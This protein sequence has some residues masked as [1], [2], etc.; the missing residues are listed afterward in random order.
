MLRKL[1]RKFVAVVMLCVTILMLVT[2]GGVNLFTMNQM[3]QHYDQILKMLVD[4]SGEF[5]KEHTSTRTSDFS[6]FGYRV[7]ITEE[8]PFETRYFLVYSDEAQN[9]TDVDVTH[10]SSVSEDEAASYAQKVFNRFIKN[11]REKGTVSEY[12]Y[13]IE[14]TEDGYMIGFADMHQNLQN[15]AYIRMISAAICLSLFLILLVLVE[16]VSGRVL[17]PLI[18]NMEKQKQFITDAGHE[19]KTPLAVISA[20]ADVLE[21]TSGK[22]E[23]IDSI[24]NQVGQMN[25]LVK[26]LLY[27]SKMEEADEMV[28]AELD[29]S[30]LVKEVSGRIATIA[31]SQQ[32]EFKMD[33]Q[34]G[35]VYKGDAKGCEHL[36]SVL[37]ENAVKYCTDGGHIEVKLYR[38][39][40]TVHLEV[41]NTGEPI[42]PSEMTRLFDRF[43]R[44]DSSRNRGTG[45]HGIGL[46]IAK[47]IVTNHRGHISVHNEKADGEDI[48]AFCVEL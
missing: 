47:A 15:I 11:K 20:N 45:G 27:L 21:L 6:G 3:W 41:R 13:L 35:I 29:L 10:I 46:S 24:R 42:E 7:E 9:V 36:V 17:K 18:L 25:E 14:E 39:G 48:V 19:L 37:T 30:E 2:V 23:W 5:P 32:K 4:N 44:P 43:Y 28:F 26:H 8:T 16:L 22:N 33:I 1:R 12:R 34:E 38:N 31:L 40:R